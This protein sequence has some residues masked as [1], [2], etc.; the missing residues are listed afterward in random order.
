MNFS[1]KT[2]EFRS[3]NKRTRIW[4]FLFTNS[5]MR[6]VVHCRCI[7]SDADHDAWSM[8]RQKR[9]HGV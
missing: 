4:H 1:D 3:E 5:L 9:L 2:E 6:I 8:Q 7:K